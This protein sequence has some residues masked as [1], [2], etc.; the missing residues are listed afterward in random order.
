MHGTGFNCRSAFQEFQ[1]NY[2]NALAKEAEKEEAKKEEG[3]LGDEKEEAKKE[4]GNLGDEKGNVGFQS[5]LRR[6][7]TGLGGAQAANA[8]RGVSRATTFSN[9][10]DPAANAQPQ[11]QG[12]S[13]AV[14]N[15]AGGFLSTVFG[16][17][18]IAAGARRLFWPKQGVGALAGGGMP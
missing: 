2:L 12:P 17:G 9:R 16:V 15:A 14:K 18:G 8:F 7:G 1:P 6:G 13:E 5:R 11:V 4:G 3:N 10:R